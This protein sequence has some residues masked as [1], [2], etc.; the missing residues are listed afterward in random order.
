MDWRQKLLEQ[1]D[2]W[3]AATGLSRA[4]L[5][6]KAAGGGRFFERIEAGKGCTVDTYQR[7]LDW[8]EADLARLAEAPAS[9]PPPAGSR[10]DGAEALARVAA[11]PTEAA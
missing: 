6:T 1:A 4:T 10:V 8:I 3:C 2:R 5:G 7:V 9:A 11:T